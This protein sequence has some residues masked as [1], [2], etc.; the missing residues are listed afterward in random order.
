VLRV[1][2]RPVWVWVLREMSLI[3]M[4]RGSSLHK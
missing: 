3:D 1:R 2:S 4:G